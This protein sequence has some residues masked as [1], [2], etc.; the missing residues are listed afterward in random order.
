[1][2]TV[3]FQ[4]QHIFTLKLFYDL[5]F[6]TVHLWYNLCYIYIPDFVFKFR[7]LQ[8]NVNDI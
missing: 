7:N 5:I 3:Q 4:R 1:M 2:F 8:Q 6:F